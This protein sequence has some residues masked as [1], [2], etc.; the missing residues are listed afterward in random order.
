MLTSKQLCDL[1]AEA[2]TDRDQYKTLFQDAY[3][4]TMPTRKGFDQNTDSVGQNRTDKIFDETAVVGVNEFAAHIQSSLIPPFSRWANLTAGNEVPEE[5][6]EEVNSELKPVTERIFDFIANSNFDQE[7]NEAMLD[8]AVGTGCLNIQEGDN[9]DPLRFQ[10]VPLTELA[11][12]DGPDGLVDD[13][14][15]RRWVKPEHLEIMFPNM[16][17]ETLEVVKNRSGGKR[18]E[19]I[20]STLRDRKKSNLRHW[21]YAAHLPGV[22]TTLASE[23]YEGRGA[24]PWVIFRWSK[25]EARLLVLFQQ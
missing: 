11:L 21:D 12:Q 4:Y 3:D 16:P 14:H 19:L 13:V 24:N 6:R 1:S 17:P 10:A 22:Q 8:L 5:N 9:I 23:Q 2:F 7:I 18:I 20:Q 15:Y 25:A